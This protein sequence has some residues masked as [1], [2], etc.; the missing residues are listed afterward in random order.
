MD[1]NVENLKNKLFKLIDLDK[2]FEVFGAESHKYT[3]N[4]C[5]SEGEIQEFE[6]NFQVKLPYEFRNF[7]LKIANGIVG[8]GY[9][10]LGLNIDNLMELKS[11]ESDFFAQSFCLQDEWNDLDL[12]QESNGSK[13]SAYF[14]QKFIQGSIA[15]AEY[16]CG[17]QARLVISGEER[18]NIWIDDR[19]NEGG[20]YPLTSHCAAFF[21]DDPEMDTYMYESVEETKEALSFYEWYENWLNRA[22]NQ[23]LQF[24]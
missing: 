7:V 16:G 12:L 14:D 9:G 1:K 10:F 24:G 4:P 13:A 11:S 18:G 8:P 23:V 21:H 17:I 6:S 5:L 20:I 3:I 15:I 19:T 22:I 2:G